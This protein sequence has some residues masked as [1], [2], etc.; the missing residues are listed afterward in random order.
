MVALN[1]GLKLIERFSRED[2]LEELATVSAMNAQTQTIT[3]SLNPSSAAVFRDA[4]VSGAEEIFPD[5]MRQA[6]ANSGAEPSFRIL[7]CGMTSEA[8]IK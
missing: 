5:A 1:E 7:G 8:A 2:Q 3:V 4:A 6:D